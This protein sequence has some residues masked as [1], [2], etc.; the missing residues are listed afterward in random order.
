MTC[1]AV[2]G[3]GP[4]VSHGNLEGCFLETKP[5]LNVQNE[6]PPAPSPLGQSGI[7][8]PRRLCIFAVLNHCCAEGERPFP[9]QWSEPL[10]SDRCIHGPQEIEGETLGRQKTVKATVPQPPSDHLLE[11]GPLFMTMAYF[12]AQA[13]LSWASAPM[14]SAG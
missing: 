2:K 13:S 11:P 12:K 5:F 7:L 6:W 4:R 3:G 10:F 1:E 8:G 9:C 14:E